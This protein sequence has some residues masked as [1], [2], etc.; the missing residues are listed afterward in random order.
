MGVG[1]EFL[2]RYGDR[3][4]ADQQ[5]LKVNA[6]G[7]AEFISCVLAPMERNGGGQIVVLSSSQGFRPIPLLAAYSAAKVLSIES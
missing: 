5:I 3:P 2:E 6:Y 1:R 4:E 7:S